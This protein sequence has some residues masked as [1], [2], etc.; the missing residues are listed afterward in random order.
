MKRWNSGSIRVLGVL[1]LPLLGIGASG[2]GDGFSILINGL[3]AALPVVDRPEQC[4]REDLVV[5]DCFSQETLVTICEEDFFGFLDCF[6]EL[7]IE[8]VCEDVVL[9]SFLVCD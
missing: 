1:L 2:C 7:I 9:D 4:F 3:G 6:D 5:T 8:V